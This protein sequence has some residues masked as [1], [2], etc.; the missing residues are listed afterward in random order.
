[1]TKQCDFNK[2][3]ALFF[4]KTIDLELAQSD[5]YNNVLLKLFIFYSII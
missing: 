5:I 4:I 3:I 2:K 1:M